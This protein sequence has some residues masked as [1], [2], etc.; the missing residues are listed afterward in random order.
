MW[1]NAPIATCVARATDAHGRRMLHAGLRSNG[2]RRFTADP[3]V[4]SLLTLNPFPGAPRTLRAGTRTPSNVMP[5]V[6]LQRWPIMI[7]F[8]PTVMPG[9]SR[10]MMNAVNAADAGVLGSGSE[11]ARRKYQ[12]GE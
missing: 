1:S 9:V 5:R 11:R 8:F 4:D 10:S 6:S 7:S 3:R 2:R 12:S